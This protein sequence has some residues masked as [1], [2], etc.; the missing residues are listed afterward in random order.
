M[1]KK[2]ESLSDLTGELIA[3]HLQVTHQTAVKR[4][5]VTCQK[6]KTRMEGYRHQDLLTNPR[7]HNRG[8]ERPK[9]KTLQDF[10]EE[11]ERLEQAAREERDRP[12]REIESKYKQSLN[13]LGKATKERILSDREDEDTWKSIVDT[14][15]VNLMSIA[16]AEKHNASMVNEY[17]AAH[18]EYYATPANSR[19]LT[20]YWSRNNIQVLS[21]QIIERSVE[22]L[23]QY[24]LLEQRPPVVETEPELLEEPPTPEPHPDDDGS[25]EGY[26]EETG[27]R[28]RKSAYLIGKMNAEQYL[29]FKRLTLVTPGGQPIFGR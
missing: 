15:G 16:Q 14:V 20:D 13:E 19:A 5:A 12:L 29:R 7:C 8:C 22:R 23:M 24:G 28:I 4:Y 26:D 17:R 2:L 27:E 9:P 25:E 18:P 10:Q 21:V 3:G 11:E 1:T 6:C